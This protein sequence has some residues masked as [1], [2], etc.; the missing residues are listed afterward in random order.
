MIPHQRPYMN[1]NADPRVNDIW[2]VHVAGDVEL[3]PPCQRCKLCD[4][5]LLGCGSGMHWQPEFSD[6]VAVGTRVFR[7]EGR[8]RFD[9]PVGEFSMPCVSYL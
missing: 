9:L 5:V 7:F 2:A 4:E 8:Q 6:W 1:A 3:A